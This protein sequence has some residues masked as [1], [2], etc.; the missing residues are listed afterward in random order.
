MNPMGLDHGDGIGMDKAGTGLGA[1]VDN[2]QGQDRGPK[3]QEE[4]SA[5]GSGQYVQSKT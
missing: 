4:K 1:R 5:V 3:S 2:C